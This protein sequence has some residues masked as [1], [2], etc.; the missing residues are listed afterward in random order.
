VTDR[1]PASR[2]DAL[3]LLAG[4]L[5]GPYEVVGPLGTGGMGEVYRARDPRLRRDVALKVLRPSLALAL[6]HVGRF[7]REARAAGSLNH[8]NIVAVFDVGSEKGVSYVVSE[9]I[10]GRTLR[11]MLALGPLP[12][13]KALEY[14]TQVAQAL[15]A[16]HERGL[17]HRDVKP[18]NVMITADEGR[19]KLLDFGLAQ[20]RNPEV[21]PD[22]STA[23]DTR[24]GR[25]QGT[26]GYMAPEQVLGHAVDHRADIFA[27]GT[28]LYEMFTGVPAFNRPLPDRKTAVLSEDPPNP[29]EI[30]PELPREAAA[31]VRRCLEKNRRERFQSARD[32]AF[33]LEQ[34]QEAEPKPPPPPEPPA[35]RW[36]TRGAVGLAVAAVIGA[37]ILGQKAPP[38][39]EQLTFRR[40]RIGGACFTPDGHSVLYS[41]AL[42]GNALEVWRLDLASGLGSPR[43]LGHAGS[44][45]LATRAGKLAL[46]LR[47]RF[48]LGERFSG[49]LAEV[50]VDGGTPRELLDEV[51]DA[52]WDLEGTNLAVVRSSGVSG[53]S[54]LEY[55]IGRVLDRTSGSIRFPRVSPDGRRIAFLKDPSSR[56]ASGQVMVADLDGTVTAL[57]GLWTSARGL[58][59]GPGGNEV[60][61]TAARGRAN[62]ALH[63]VSLR[64]RERLV[65]EAP[66]SLTLWDV[67]PEGRVLL[68]RDDERRAVV[69]VP[70]GETGER[71]FSWFDRPG[72]VDLSADGLQ[73]LFDDRF[74]TYLRSTDGEPPTYL[75]LSDWFA[76]DLSPDGKTVLATAPTSDRLVLLPV[77]AGDPRPLPPH[78]ITTYRG[79]WWFPDGRRILFT[80]S[81]PG[82]KLRSYVQ[83]VDGGPPRELTPE[84]TWGLSIS[85]DGKWVAATGPG[86]RISLW[87]VAGGP[88]RPVPGSEPEE[89]PVAWSADGRWLWIFRRG[90]VPADVSRLEIATGRREHWKKLVP[91]DPAGVYS[92]IEFE[93]T[94]DGRAY[95]Y[96]YTRL[97]S[98]LYLAKDLK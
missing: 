24:S 84:D 58:A 33:H 44:D 45:V 7:L 14:G 75:G 23:D 87:P 64:G 21:G 42:T 72:L 9:L 25:F 48:V 17:C 31:V 22:D 43:S 51:E 38:T 86:H 77:G 15:G 26:P 89:R 5:L 96:G 83:D 13:R 2:K 70:P 56:G 82:H 36:L 85:P 80:G 88:P 12:Y 27:L 91:P 78:G 50:P 49:T 66:T 20:L 59:W 34:L 74:G 76:D 55:P 81:T 8:P 90:Y 57:T 3:S 40:G 79:A 69:G 10:E 1:V 35:L 46:S 32:L 6:E 11:E 19:V 94:P 93:V 41:E 67:H 61:F 52:H 71:D 16:A 63:A 47:R 95:F 28:V 37:M 30:N 18:G 54:R 60:W 65:H 4:D 98:Q 53:E 97:L 73:L 29:R 62:R 92:I 68:T 39:F